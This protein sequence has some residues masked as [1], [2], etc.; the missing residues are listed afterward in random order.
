[1]GK[2]YTI[3]EVFT[4]DKLAVRVDDEKQ[5]N[6]IIDIARE[7]GANGYPRHSFEDAKRIESKGGVCLRYD[8][9]D[10]QLWFSDTDYYLDNGYTVVPYY[11]IDFSALEKK[12]ESKKCYLAGK[13]YRCVGYK[14][15]EK[16]F[17]IGKVYT[18]ED[19]G[20]IIS[21]T[22]FR[23]PHDLY[24][25]RGDIITYLSDYYDFEEV[26][27]ENP[28][29]YQI[30][31]ECVDDVTTAKMIVDGKEVRV[32]T[33]KRNPADQFDFAVGARYAFDRLWDK[34]P[35]EVEFV[36]GFKI[37]D[38]VRYVG[39]SSNKKGRVCTVRDFWDESIGVEFDDDVH[40]H[41]L[42]FGKYKHTC[43]TGHGWWCRSDELTHGDEQKKP[44]P[45]VGGF[46]V[47]DRVRCIE[48]GQNHYDLCGTVVCIDD[49]HMIG[50]EFDE[51][52]YGHNL[53]KNG[54]HTLH[55]DRGWWCDFTWLEK[56]N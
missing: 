36:D 13:K 3:D 23:Y 56:L 5:W 8:R 7:R 52:C 29:R 11:R 39:D 25:H 55:N 32:G 41:R 22:G 44:T 19:N 33:S 46:K 50:V 48:K 15:K 35:K 40:G 9:V 1:M 6:R 26:T 31:I 2:H 10:K 54:H 42:E 21:D 51:D 4:T 14:R 17:T 47:G 38:R 45:S 18:L 24:A 27:D 28:S 53:W 37:G 49:R 43:K 12:P 30:I 20:D 34:L 16:F